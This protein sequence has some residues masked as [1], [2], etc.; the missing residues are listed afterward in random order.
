MIWMGWAGVCNVVC[1]T[2]EGGVRFNR[3]RWD[4]LWT[5]KD[6]NRISMVMERIMQMY[7]IAVTVHATRTSAGGLQEQVIHGW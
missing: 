4:R 3:R 5:G 7:G 6:I 2:T 1:V